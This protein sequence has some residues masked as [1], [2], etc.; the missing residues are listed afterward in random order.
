MKV[1]VR[2]VAVGDRNG[3]VAPMAAVGVAMVE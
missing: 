2:G 1:K 3:G